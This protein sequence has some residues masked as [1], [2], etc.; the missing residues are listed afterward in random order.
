MVI[1]M[2]KTRKNAAVDSSDEDLPATIIFELL[3]NERRQLAI[4]YLTRTVGA[5][6][7]SDL[8]DQIA[9]WEGEHTREQYERICTSLVHI[10]VPKLRE[11]GILRYDETNETVTLQETAD[12]LIPYLELARLPNSP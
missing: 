7:I 11:A 10:H 9:L 5:V 4:Q 3:A 12:Q 1:P 2:P 8:G 6:P